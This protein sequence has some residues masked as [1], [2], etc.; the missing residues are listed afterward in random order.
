MKIL[1][2]LDHSL[3]LHSGYTFR[4]RAI[5]KAQQAAG[6]DVRAVTG[7]RHD[8]DGP[9]SN[10]ATNSPLVES[11]E[12]LIFHRT[13]GEADGPAG[14]REWREIGLFAD[15]IDKVIA[16]WQPDILHAHSPAICGHAAMRAARKHDLPLVYEIL[17]LIH[18]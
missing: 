4:T 15:G 3:P 7:L 1:H 6:I 2:V 16:D 5:L 8:V 17:S 18:I 11:Y 12:G 10:R 14:V 13:P 9:T